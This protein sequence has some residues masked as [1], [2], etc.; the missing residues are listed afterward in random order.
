MFRKSTNNP[1]VPGTLNRAYD[2]IQGGGVET[3]GQRY[4]GLLGQSLVMGNSDALKV[5]NAAIGT[6][7]Q[8]VYQ[9]VKFKS[10]VTRGQ[11]LTWDT[12][13]NNGQNDFEV[14]ATVA[15][16][17]VFTAGICLLTDASAT[18]K[19]GWIQT[20]GMASVLYGTVTS[21]VIGNLVIRTSLTTATADA[22]ADAGTTFATNGGAKLFL[23]IAYETPASDTVKRVWLNLMGVYPNVG[24]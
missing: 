7:F 20:A 24:N 12:L 10:A 5:S 11:I 22:I 17:S 14:T 6:L 4:P 1:Y 13:A 23:G 2:D 19:F 16:T 18:N 3:V 21:A 15:A 9:Y 8:G